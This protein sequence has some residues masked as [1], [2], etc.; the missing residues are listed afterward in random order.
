MPDSTYLLIHGGGSSARYWD[1]LIPLLDR[2]AVAVDLPGRGSRPADITTLS[3]SDLVDSV[4]ADATA[5]MPTGSIVVVAH[6]S[7]G[8]VVPGVVEA[9]G[10]RVERIVLNAALAPR[11]GERALDCMRDDHRDGLIMVVEAA[12]EKGEVI[13]LPGAPDDPEQFRNAYGGEP[14]TDEQ[15]AALT[16]PAA[17]VADTVNHYFEPIHWSRIAAVPVTYILNERDRPVR[18]ARQEEMITWLPTPPDVIRLDSG[19]C[20]A[21]TAPTEFAGLLAS[22]G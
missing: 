13:T 11:E 1:L 21:V 18:P 7:G 6:S 14:L 8:L 22:I 5:L 2:P 16:D 3:L 20:P 19:H 12:A 15:L 17:C 10:D 9:L 4:V